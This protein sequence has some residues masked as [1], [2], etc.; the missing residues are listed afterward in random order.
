[1]GYYFKDSRDGKRV[2]LGCLLLFSSVL[3]Y[4]CRSEVQPRSIPYPDATLE[5]PFS[6]C[7]K[8]TE[9]SIFEY[10]VYQRASSLFTLEEVHFYC[11][12]AGIWEES[13]RH[14]WGLK[15]LRMTH[16]SRLSLEE[17][18]DGCGGFSDCSFEVIDARPSEDTLIQ[19]ERCSQYV[20]S[21][22]R[23]CVLHAMQRWYSQ[24]PSADQVQTVLEGFPQLPDQATEYIA[25]VVYCQG[26]GS[27]EG[28]LRSHQNCR[29]HIRRLQKKPRLCKRMT[30]SHFPKNPKDSGNR[31]R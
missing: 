7:R 20:V 24:K 11:P 8:Y 3:L 25:N 30:G 28:A 14:T 19:L 22:F 6:L 9:K 13:C 26:I 10:C 16:K 31:K 12:M 4:A 2:L 17:L 5:A 1:M 18:L 15:R 27:C 21:D 23:D 29:R